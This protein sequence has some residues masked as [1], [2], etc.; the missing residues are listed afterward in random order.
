MC[1]AYPG[2]VLSVDCAGRATVR[3]PDRT[4]RVL[5]TLLDA[6]DA[7][8][9]VAGQWLL[10]QSG[11]ALALLTPDEAAARIELLDQPNEGVS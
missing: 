10:I 9:V 8:P 1:Q 6:D 2:Q 3:L 11:I 4:Q 5:L 7:G